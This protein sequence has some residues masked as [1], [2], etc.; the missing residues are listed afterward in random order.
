MR[1]SLS[2][3][4]TAVAETRARNRRE[5]MKARLLVGTAVLTFAIGLIATRTRAARTPAPS[6]P[7]VAAVVPRAAPPTPTFAAPKLTAP[8]SAPRAAAPR[9]PAFAETEPPVTADTANT[10]AVAECETLCKRHRWRL[11]AEP[12]AMAI[13][14][15]PDDPTLFLGLAQSAHARNH[16]AE[17]GEWAKRASAL[18]PT[19]A[20]AFIIQAHAAADVGDAAAATRDF[21]R[22]LAL[23]PRGWHSKEARKALRER[24]E[25]S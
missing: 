21:R 19:L 20:E 7:K 22:Y 5:T 17:A 14:T 4:Q 8:I 6:G 12:C 1:A 11:A 16:L 15:R 2:A 24:P 13:K 10:S 3:V 23:A 18:D 9:A 25:S